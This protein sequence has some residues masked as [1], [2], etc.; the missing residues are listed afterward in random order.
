MDNKVCKEIVKSE[1]EIMFGGSK[2]K[3]DGHHSHDDDD[4]TGTKKTID[5]QSLSSK[6]SA[7]PTSPEPSKNIIGL[8]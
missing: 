5:S 7:S 1:F 2:V 3:C 4:E 6:N 8:K